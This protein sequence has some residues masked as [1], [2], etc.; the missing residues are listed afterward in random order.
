MDERIAQLDKTR[1]Q[2]QDKVRQTQEARDRCA[3]KLETLTQRIHDFVAQKTV[4]VDEAAD[5]LARAQALH[6]ELSTQVQQ[7]SSK[8]QQNKKIREQVRH[9]EKTGAQLAHTY[10]EIAALAFTTTGKLTGKERVSFETY[11]QTQWLDRILV[12]ANRRLSIMSEGRYELVRHQGSRDGSGTAQTGLELDVFDSFTGKPRAASSL[13][14]G[15][16]FKASLSLAL[17]LSDIVQAHAGG[18][19]LDTMFVDEGFGS[20]DE[21]SLNLAVRTLH[22]MTGSHKLVGIIS[23]VDEL[24]HNMERKIVVERGRAGSTLHLEG[25]I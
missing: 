25:V 20:L 4:R 13:S 8:I 1:T 18:I 2:A 12:A 10:G 17:G 22:D 19:K 11:V 9:T 7:V 14:G 23:H 24:K 16:S 6:E 5:E 15:E 21:E 3:A